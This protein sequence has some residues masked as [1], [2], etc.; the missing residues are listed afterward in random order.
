MADVFERLIADQLLQGPT[1]MVH[2]IL[3]LA[4]ERA[5]Y[6]KLDDLT[7]GRP[8]LTTWMRAMSEVPSMRRTAPP[9]ASPA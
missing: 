2:L 1:R 8:Q 9:Q 3:A 4:L 6:C 5:R 7:D